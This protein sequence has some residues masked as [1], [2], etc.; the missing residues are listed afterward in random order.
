MENIFR[1]RKKNEENICCRFLL[2]I[3]VAMNYANKECLSASECDDWAWNDCS[4][5]CGLYDGECLMYWEESSWCCGTG[6]CC[7]SWKYVC[8]SGR[9]ARNICPY[10]GE[11]WVNCG[12]SN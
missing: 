4:S 6:L 9:I 10:W 8:Q 12:F 1:R 5:Y 2:L 3:L 11:D 7:S